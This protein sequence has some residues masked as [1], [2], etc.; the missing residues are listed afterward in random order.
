MYASQL[1]VKMAEC[2]QITAVPT[3]APFTLGW[4]PNFDTVRVGWSTA[5]QESVGISMVSRSCSIRFETHWERFSKLGLKQAVATFPLK[6][7]IFQPC[8]RLTLRRLN[9]PA[10]D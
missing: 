8:W 6:R 9:V 2:Q 10:P 3:L 4:L 7:L 5:P 1:R